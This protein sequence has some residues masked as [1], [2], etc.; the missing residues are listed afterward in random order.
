MFSIISKI[1]KKNFLSILSVLFFIFVISLFSYFFYLYHNENSYK[2]ILETNKTI[3]KNSIYG[4]I[5]WLG[6]KSIR[7][8]SNEL[9]FSRIYDKIKFENPSTIELEMSQSDVS[10]M[11]NQIE[12]FKKKGFIKDEL[13]FWKNA[14]LK[15]DGNDYPIEFKFNGTSASRFTSSKKD[16]FSL[17]IKYKKNKKINQIREFN[18]IKIYFD[19]DEN[20]PTII[21]N[22]LAK[23]FGLLSPKGETKILKINGVNIGFY[24]LQE[25]H[26]KEWFEINEITNYSILKN[27]DD[28]DRKM[29]S[30]HTSDLD[31]NEKNIEVSGSGYDEAIAFGAI[32]NL[33]NA[34]KKNETNKIL[35][36]IDVD[37]FAKFLAIKT[38]IND[39][40]TITGDNIKYIYDF[41][42]GRFKIL[43]RQ[44]GGIANP[45]V[46][47]VVN[48]NKSLFENNTYEKTLSHNLFKILISDKDFR[49]K[50]DFYLKKL[51]DKKEDI[52]LNADKAYNNAYKN[53]IFSD[54][55]L[56]HQKY[57][58][59]VFFENLD[60]NFDKIEKYLDYSKV[61][62]SFEKFKNFVI[63]SITNDSFA[64]IK[65]KRIFFK[66]KNF[67]FKDLNFETIPSVD[68]IDWKFKYPEYKIEIPVEKMISSIE[69]QNLI[70]GKLIKDEH[71]YLNE[72]KTFG[73]S[74][75]K[76][77]VTS[78][79]KNKI[80]F[81]FDN[82]NLT[83]KKGEYIISQNI[84][85]PNNIKTII[86]EGTKITLK[87]NKSMIFK[88]SLLAKGTEEEKI[89]VSNHDKNNSFGTFAVLGFNKNINNVVIENFEIR[90]GSQAIV[91]GV[92][93]LGQ[94]SI[95]NSNVIISKSKIMQSKSDDGANIRNSKVN[96]TNNIFKDN[97]FDQI[98]LDFCEG[99]LMKNTFSAK[100]GSE[101]ITGDGIDLSGS[102]V[103]ISENLI[104][105]FQ[106]KAISA[107][108]KSKAIINN[109]LFKNNNIAVAI[110]DESKTYIFNN[111]YENNMVRFSMYVKK[112]FFDIPQL[113]LN[114]INYL[115]YDLNLLKEKNDI[116]QGNIYLIEDLEKDNF[117]REF[118]KDVKKT[119]I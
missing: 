9:N 49:N 46:S 56:R 58:Q 40:A 28:W 106:D 4:K 33:F 79:S 14:K 35:N 77:L 87:K 61:Y 41:T 80:K 47:S 73:L 30:S 84:V 20:I 24:Y 116:K 48:F 52:L 112:Y 42:N 68:Y 62:V 119:R 78:L 108:E 95:H 5:Y 34:I 54:I 66:D 3:N 23:N 53:L 111:E 86:E 92:V 94:L 71:I 15:S 12:I 57:L 1:K 97:K 55:K 32:K 93:F 17:R 102:N 36:L 96:I 45:I 99:V 25:R 63:L 37:Y 117:Y 113:Y 83:I 69:F 64:P 105:N 27:N 39:N 75:K 110:K 44:E 38:L 85:V 16:H 22:N 82:D 11:N 18:L 109:N 6:F 67:E 59:K 7:K 88:G 21:F 114:K 103:I 29:T 51:L 65:I 13:N 74:D 60:N 90:G 107:G 8:A 10:F 70:T 118:K 50:K 98:D 43:F 81:N 76:D 72:I 101:E 115:D 100:K 19:G 91:D 26:S 31:L 104:L 89:E 2:K